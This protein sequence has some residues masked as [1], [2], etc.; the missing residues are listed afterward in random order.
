MHY[1]STRTIEVTFHTRA[2]FKEIE[3][4]A[5][6]IMWPGLVALLRCLLFIEWGFQFLYGYICQYFP[7]SFIFERDLLT[8]WN[9]QHFKY[10][11]AVRRGC[12]LT[13]GQRGRKAGW[14]AL[15]NRN[16]SCTPHMWS[17]TVWLSWGHCPV[18]LLSCPVTLRGLLGQVFPHI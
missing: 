13:H 16:V 11:G 4:P 17:H 18:S 6:S 5:A 2:F 14:R 10:H 1:W 12:L 9:Y 8:H 7:L 15:R 3:H